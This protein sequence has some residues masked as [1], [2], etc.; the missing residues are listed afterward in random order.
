MRHWT[1]GLL[2]KN[3]NSYKAE[4]VLG[5]PPPPNFSASRRGN[6]TVRGSA[7]GATKK[8]DRSATRLQAETLRN[9]KYF[10]GPRV[11]DFASWRITAHIHISAFRVERAEYIT[12]LTR[13]GLG[14]RKL[15]LS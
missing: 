15:R 8:G 13:H 14:G 9:N 6:A 11:F 12:R 2:Y 5:W 3:H 7:L 10:I 1:G 4:T